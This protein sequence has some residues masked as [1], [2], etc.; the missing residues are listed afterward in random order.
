MGVIFAMTDAAWSIERE[1]C[2]LA[3]EASLPAALARL[4]LTSASN[5]SYLLKEVQPWARSGSETYSYVFSVTEDSTLERV[6]RLKA[7]VAAP[8]GSDL[9]TI[10]ESWLR[11]RKLL[12]NAG[13][14]TPALFASGHG[15]LLEEEIPLEIAVAIIGAGRNSVLAGLLGTA[16]A[17]AKLGF[18]PV[19]PFCDMRSHGDDAVFVDFGSDLGEPRGSSIGANAIFQQLTQQLSLWGAELAPED[20]I[21]LGEVFRARI[22]HTIQ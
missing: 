19:S 15:V 22:H 2:K 20:E 14:Q 1:L 7:C 3:Q 4:G 18:A 16:A 5:A 12:Q 10:L 13:V 21:H 11:R 8:S 6:Y 9:E 17:L